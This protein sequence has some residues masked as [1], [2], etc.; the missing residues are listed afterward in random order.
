[1]MIS[2]IAKRDYMYKINNN[3]MYSVFKKNYYNDIC[4]KKKPSMYIYRFVYN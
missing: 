1:M 2:L 3:I 4:M